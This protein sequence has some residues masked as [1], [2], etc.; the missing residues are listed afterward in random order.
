MKQYKDRLY[1]KDTIG[2]VREWY[3]IY[4]ETSYIKHYGVLNGEVTQ[5]YTQVQEGKNIGKSNETSIAQQVLKECESAYKDQLKK[6]YKI[7]VKPLGLSD[8]LFNNMLY[9]DLP[10]SKTDENNYLKPMKAQTYKIGCMIFPVICQ[11]KINGVRATISLIDKFNGLFGTTKEAVIK[12]KEGLVY[13]I[14]HIEARA[15][16]IL[17]MYDN[18]VLDGEIYIS[19]EHVTSIGGAARNPNNPLHRELAFICYDL[20]IPILTQ[21]ARIDLKNDMIMP[22]TMLMFLISNNDKL[23]RRSIFSCPSILINNEQEVA[24]Y[25]D[26]FIR[27]GFE[28]SILR[29]IEADYKFGSRAKTMRKCKRWHDAEFEII[30]IVAGERDGNAIFVCKNDLNDIRFRVDGT[31]EYLDSKYIVNKKDYIGKFATVQF[32]ERT[33]NDIPFH[34]TLIGIRDYES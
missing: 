30:D 19:G 31:V 17:Q 18:I 23:L 26:E 27:Y 14:K 13:N 33:V 8:E 22:T 5:S 2:K 20:S 12:S 6:G 25:R 7:I 9:S 29:D 34:T 4:D 21:E 28:G 15:F 24:H 16:E 10:T 1:I 3:L 32:Y 11:P